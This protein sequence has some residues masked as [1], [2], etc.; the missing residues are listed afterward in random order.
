M[1]LS[2]LLFTKSLFLLVKLQVFNMWS[3][4][5]QATTP[6]IR[7]STVAPVSFLYLRTTLYCW[8]VPTPVIS[9]PYPDEKLK[10]SGGGKRWSQ[11]SPEFSE[12]PATL[13]TQ[14][15]RVNQSQ[16]EA[17]RTGKRSLLGCF[18]VPPSSSCR[19]QLLMSKENRARPRDRHRSEKP[20]RCRRRGALRCAP[21]RPLV[22]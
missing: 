10:N 18:T 19:A 21:R 5:Y 16:E 6:Y 13:K 22:L 20:R 14:Q 9:T 1:R 12:G 8:V 15:K 17:K 2:V 7:T 3:C 4:D 11:G